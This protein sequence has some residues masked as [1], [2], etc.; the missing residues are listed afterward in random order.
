[1]KKD[2]LLILALFLVSSFTLLIALS[3]Q[4][5]DFRGKAAAPDVAGNLIIYLTKNRTTGTVTV[6]NI[7]AVAGG[8]RTT[9]FKSA[10]T[11]THRMSR[12]DNGNVTSTF[13]FSFHEEIFSL[14]PKPGTAEKTGDPPK[15]LETSFAVVEMPYSSA[16]MY[17]LTDKKTNVKQD[18][19]SPMV[20]LAISQVVELNQSNVKGVIQPLSNN[21]GEL[22]NTLDIVFIASAYTDFSRFASDVAAMS[23]FLLTVSPFREYKQAITISRI[24]N[25]RDLGCYQAGRMI[26]CSQR[27]VYE[28]ASHVPHDT[29]VVV[30]NSNIYGGAAYS[31]GIAMIY[32]DISEWAKQV[33]VHEI[34]HS[35]GELG[36]EYDYNA[37]WGGGKPRA[38]CDWAGC[39]KWINSISGTGCFLVCGN[40]NLYRSTDNGSL[41]RTLNP[42]GGFKFETVGQNAMAAKIAYY[43]T[44]PTLSLP[45]P[46][47]PN[48]TPIPCRNYSFNI[49]WGGFGTDDGK[50]NQPIGIDLDPSNNIYVVD[51]GNTRIQ[52]FNSTGKFLRKW[53]TSGSTNGSFNSP[54]DISVDGNSSYVYVADTGNHRIQKF[55][56]DGKFILSFG[57]YGS[58]DGLF[59]SPAGI[60]ANGGILISD[61]LNHRIHRF[62][63]NGIRTNQWGSFGTD[64]DKFNTPL[65]LVNVPGTGYVYI[66]DK[67]NH[68]IQKFDSGRTFIKNWGQ[69]GALDGQ[70]KSPTDVSSDSLGF[71]Y[72]VDQNNHRIQKFDK[73]GNFIGKFGSFG[74]NN[75]QFK[76]PQYLAVDSAGRNIYVSDTGNNRIQKFSCDII[77]P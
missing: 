46:T 75:G 7:S 58:A 2:W 16:S 9:P 68:R 40:N 34:G 74:S 53:G 66:A 60:F 70:F 44:E 15:K 76:F 25:T 31:G 14:P 1:M 47:P 61:T 11:A 56:T 50:F 71:I 30:H 51:K 18:V 5:T 36:D 10:T 23:N 54:T 29:I 32:R 35:L 55:S 39:G 42:N 21:G 6:E 64:N 12:I 8:T 57:T 59:N 72:V 63:S 69:Y 67:L 19:P 73:E 38:N 62:Q 22:N 3:K 27:T 37:P 77:S 4:K 48:P 20:S 45:S 43:T 52:K 26:N 49:K 28:V 33:A 65:G 24:D 13:D 41:M 17:Q